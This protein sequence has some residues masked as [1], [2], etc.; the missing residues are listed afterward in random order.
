MWQIGAGIADV[1]WGCSQIGAVLTL[2]TQTGPWYGSYPFLPFRTSLGLCW[3]TEPRACHFEVVSA[4]ELA[5]AVPKGR[6]QM[7]G[8]LGDF[9]SSAI[10]QGALDF[11]HGTR[12]S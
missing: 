12:K 10:S 2:V 8:A 3:A 4:S 7:P 6:E 5:L 1:Y 9:L 11:R